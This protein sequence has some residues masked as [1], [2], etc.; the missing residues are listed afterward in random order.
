M[1]KNKSVVVARRKFKVSVF[2]VVFFVVMVGFGNA[3]SNQFEFFPRCSVS[4]MLAWGVPFI[5]M[6]ISMFI[7]VV[8]LTD[9]LKAEEEV[10]N[11]EKES[12]VTK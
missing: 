9:F 12:E 6:S 2:W 10:I 8:R 1:T 7:S 5:A 4:G 3:C 11:L